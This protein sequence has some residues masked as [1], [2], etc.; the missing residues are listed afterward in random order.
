MKL[1]E[2]DFQE[3]LDLYEKAIEA[4]FFIPHPFDEHEIDEKGSLTVPDKYETTYI[5]KRVGYWIAYFEDAFDRIPQKRPK[6]AEREMN[7]I[8]ARFGSGKYILPPNILEGESI[9]D[10]RI[11]DLKEHLTFKKR[12][13]DF[14]ECVLLANAS[15]E[16]FTH[17]IASI[18]FWFFLKDFLGKNNG[19]TTEG[20]Q[21][22]EHQTKESLFSKEF[23][24]EFLSLPTFEEKLKFFEKHNLSFS[25]RHWSQEID[26]YLF[27]EPNSESEIIA[28][29]EAVLRR[30]TQIL[31][32]EKREYY[33]QLLNIPIRTFEELKSDF[34]NRVK[35]SSHKPEKFLELELQ[36]LLNLW[37]EYDKMAKKDN[38]TNSKEDQKLLFEDEYSKVVRVLPDDLSKKRLKIELNS[39]RK[40]VYEP[41]IKYRIF[42]EKLDLEA[43]IEVLKKKEKQPDNNF[44]NAA[45]L[46]KIKNLFDK[47]KP[48]YFDFMRAHIEKN[49]EPEYRKINF[50]SLIEDEGK[51]L[52]SLLKEIISNLDKCLL[53]KE[54]DPSNGNKEIEKQ[55]ELLETKRRDFIKKYKEGEK[56]AVKERVINVLPTGQEWGYREN[57]NPYESEARYWIFTTSV[58]IDFLNWYLKNDLQAATLETNRKPSKGNEEK[59]PELTNDK[60][61]EILQN[62]KA[63]AHT[64]LT[65]LNGYNP[66]KKKIMRQVDFDK[67][68]GYVDLMIEQERLPENIEQL[69]QIA[70]PTGHIRYLFYCIH[71]DLY[72]THRIRD[73]FIDFLYSTFKQ[74]KAERSTTKT[75]FSFEPESWKHDLEVMKG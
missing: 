65:L 17:L 19:K 57:P 55:I 46:E 14:S 6:I 70:I 25:A 66:Q 26:D 7:D 12:Y 40:L 62:L 35:I 36:A 52:E 20:Q 34:Y 24:Q 59:N 38:L 47:Y 67:L 11:K 4:K 43:E 63:K 15:Q 72:T 48:D 31:F 56:F 75:K 22:S 18:Q 27:L 64:H 39:R 3:I 21:D 53:F 32:Q 33:S 9:R 74:F 44:G 5:K 45:L 2:T 71:K 8:Q 16:V 13:T 29:N 50:E 41:Y 30:E 68:V 37:T 23:V 42:L 10:Y 28:Y 69:D 73:Y 51:I 54:Y 60:S 1:S 58:E 61:N 49:V